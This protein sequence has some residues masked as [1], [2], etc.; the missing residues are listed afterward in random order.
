MKKP[1]LIFM[2]GEDSFSLVQ[3]LNRWKNA[4]IEKYG[5]DMNLEVLDGEEMDPSEI[6][7]IIS[8]LPFLAEKRLV[9]L[10]DFQKSRNADEKKE[11]IPILDHLADTTVFVLAETS[12]P[13]KRS[14]LFKHLTKVATL[15]L[16]TKPKGAQLSTWILRQVQQHQGN[17]DTRTANYLS[18]AVGDDLWALKNEIQK[19]C[20]FA[21]GKAITPE[22][23][24]AL[25]VGSIEQ[26][27]FTMTDQLAKRDSSGALKTLRKL[28]E[29]GLGAP[30]LF[31]MIARQFR[32]MLEMKSM[33][34]NR[35]PQNA[36][37]K[38]MGVHPF[39]VTTTIKQCK[40]FSIPQLK[41][42]LN[43]LLD[44]DRRLK[45]GHIHLRT[46]EEEQYLLAIERIIV[47]L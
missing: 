35:I 45:T 44:I 25:V 43:K 33:L 5:G 41:R 42:T 34:E 31:A 19:L 30:H 24:D 36:I 12:P 10:K 4:F 37:A 14:A 2:Y 21:Q 3:E 29:Q 28:Q 47:S 26:S 38:K 9:I 17:M 39:V 32:L 46:R 20:L 8:A 6:S 1:N 15:R 22:A 23:V 7:S 13:D 16:F 40:N 27:I 11:L 18:S